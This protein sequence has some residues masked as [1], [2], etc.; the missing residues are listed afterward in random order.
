M[1]CIAAFTAPLLHK[2]KLVITVH[3]CALLYPAVLC[4]PRP[5]AELR[6]SADVDYDA[7]RL[8]PTNRVNQRKAG[9]TQIPR[10]V[11]RSTNPA[12]NRSER[13]IVMVCLL[14]T[15]SA[16]SVP[17]RVAGLVGRGSVQR[18]PVPVLSP[19]LLEC[20]RD[21]GPGR[22]GPDRRRLLEQEV[23]QRFARANRVFSPSAD[24]F[25]AACKLLANFATREG[26]IADAHPS[27][28]HNALLATS[29]GESGITLTTA[30]S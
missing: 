22:A 5:P 25:S 8:A 2:V 17:L 9:C 26:W 20:R 27:L 21:S 3:D 28:V 11:L 14:S 10:A 13:S 12:I 7:R 24:A 30:R 4:L 16:M 1:W 6:H 19:H 23:V 18:V 29:C 15:T